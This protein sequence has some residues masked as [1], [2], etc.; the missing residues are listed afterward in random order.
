[1]RKIGLY[2]GSYNPIHQGH[3]K[4]AEYMLDKTEMEEVWFM[5]SPQ[6]PLKEN[7]DLLDEHLRLS[8]VKLATKENPGLRASDFEFNLPRPSY[9]GNTLDQLKKQYPT[10]EF[11]MILGED[12]IRYF[13]LWRD[14]E[15]ILNEIVI[16]VYPRA[17]LTSDAPNE[18]L[19]RHENVRYQA[20]APL[21]DVSSTEIREAIENR[22]N[23]RTL[24]PEGV[25][26]F[27]QE[28]HLYE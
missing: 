18:E 28:N 9:T 3:L 22:E 5:I 16:Y 7:D 19:L 23:V 11:Q 26:D 15:R 2:F 27:I 8:M 1:M 13:H 21:F 20:N 17:E 10:H 4:I 14:Y 6:N 24:I 25:L 12:N